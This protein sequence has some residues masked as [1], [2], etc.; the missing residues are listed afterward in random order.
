MGLEQ[1]MVDGQSEVVGQ[2][3]G[4]PGEIRTDLSTV[5]LKRV[6]WIQICFTWK[7]AVPFV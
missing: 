6:T 7:Y 3:K 4:R 1:W 2:E 5:K